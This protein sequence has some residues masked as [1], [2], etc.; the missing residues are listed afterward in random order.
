MFYSSGTICGI[1]VKF[2]EQTKSV[3]SLER[4]NLWRSNFQKFDYEEDHR[5][6]CSRY[7]D[8]DRRTKRD[9]WRVPGL[10]H[11]YRWLGDRLQAH[12]MSL[13]YEGKT[14]ASDLVAY[15]KDTLS[16]M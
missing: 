13:V 8:L 12:N 16:R 4:A 5:K 6:L 11:C 3:C 15:V 10:K 7:V 2:H 1:L 9:P 14:P